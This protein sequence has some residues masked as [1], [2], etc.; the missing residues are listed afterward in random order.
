ML[1]HCWALS[2]PDIIHCCHSHPSISRRL[3]TFACHLFVRAIYLYLNG[4]INRIEW[5]LC[6][7]CCR[8]HEPRLF[9]MMKTPHRVS[10]WVCCSAPG[11]VYVES[12]SEMNEFCEILQE[13]FHISQFFWIHILVLICFWAAFVHIATVWGSCPYDY[14]A[15]VFKTGWRSQTEMG[16]S[17][18]LPSVRRAR[19]RTLASVHTQSS[20]TTLN[21]T[22]SLSPTKGHRGR[23]TA[24]HRRLTSRPAYSS[25]TAGSSSCSTSGRC[26]RTLMEGP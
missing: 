17:F 7:S 23:G 10:V 19:G 24:S 6:W 12:F 21:L 2:M 1:W 14:F 11:R 15:Q 26:P 4:G 18:G 22:S 25:L 5:H 9:Q 13:M 20:G 8:C 3:E 16:S